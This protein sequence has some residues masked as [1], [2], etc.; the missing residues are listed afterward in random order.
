MKK[1]VVLI[2]LLFIPIAM[3]AG[4]TYFTN[5]PHLVTDIIKIDGIRYT[6][7][8]DTNT[9]AVL[10]RSDYNEFHLREDRCQ[11]K[12]Y[13][14][15]CF[16]EFIHANLIPDVTKANLTASKLD[17]ISYVS[18]NESKCKKKISVGCVEDVECASNNC[19]HGKCSFFESI[20]GDGFCDE[21]SFTCPQDCED[22]TTTT[23]TTTTIATTTTTTLLV[24]TTVQQVTTSSVAPTTFISEDG[25]NVSRK[26]LLIILVITVIM[27]ALIVLT[28]LYIKKHPRL[29]KIANVDVL[30]KKEKDLDDKADVLLENYQKQVDNLVKN[31]EGI[32]PQEMPKDDGMA[33]PQ[34]IDVPEVD[35][36]DNII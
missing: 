10:L 14:K 32:P 20:C 27:V 36:K 8:Y 29:E 30:K 15:I 7:Y 12:G 34:K 24:T 1:E 13:Y 18:G 9:N 2:F 26:F 6:Q 22:P 23:T 17:C 25:D 28:F 4:T 21:E 31:D 11:T 35:S 5:K 33:S 19:L 16:V 3:S